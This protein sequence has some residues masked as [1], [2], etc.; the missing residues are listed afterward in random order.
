MKLCTRVHLD[1][2]ISFFKA[3]VLH[4]FSHLFFFRNA[5]VKLHAKNM[6]GIHVWRA[7]RVFKMFKTSREMDV[8]ICDKN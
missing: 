2:G 1:G 8:A 4:V 5:G 6:R 7:C 3:L